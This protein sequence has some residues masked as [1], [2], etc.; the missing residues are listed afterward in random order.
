MVLSLVKSV[1]KAST[2][3]GV[4]YMI[5]G[6][7]ERREMF[8]ET[9]ETVNK[10]A[11]AAFKYGITPIVCVGETFEERE[12]RKNKRTCRRPSEKSIKRFNSRT[13]S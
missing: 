12:A 7:S 9:D 2:D 5:I 1:L 3:L 13:N 4:E 8:N 11:H 10:K 6:H